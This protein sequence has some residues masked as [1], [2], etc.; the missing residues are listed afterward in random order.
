MVMVREVLNCK[1]GKVGAMIEKFKG[2]NEILADMGVDGFRLYTDVAGEPFWTLV[3]EREYESVDAS[4]ELEAKVMA[5]E[6]AQAVMQGYHD[7]I[8]AGRREIYKVVP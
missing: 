1:P 5:D 6:R 8:Q 2:L 7:L 3:I 4:S